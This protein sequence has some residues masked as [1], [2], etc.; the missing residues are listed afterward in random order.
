MAGSQWERPRGLQRYREG[1]VAPAARAAD[2]LPE[3]SVE[4]S[5]GCSKDAQGHQL[6]TNPLYPVSGCQVSIGL[7]SPC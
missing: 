5:T 3:T 6:R 1:A 2:A 7:V 4:G